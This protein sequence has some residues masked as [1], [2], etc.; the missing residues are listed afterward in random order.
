MAMWMIETA[1]AAFVALIVIAMSFVLLKPE[2]MAGEQREVRIGAAIY[3][4]I[5]GAII[6]FGVVP[7]RMS[8]TKPDGEVSWLPLL[9]SFGLIIFLRMGGLGRTPGVKRVTQAYQKAMLRR[10]IAKSERRLAK[11]EG[12]STLPESTALE[13]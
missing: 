1:I 6:G 10:T 4:V 13:Q 12:R 8:M 2:D 5:L 7:L 3:G 9:A 11:L